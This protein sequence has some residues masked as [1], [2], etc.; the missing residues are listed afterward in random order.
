MTV[1][2][3]SV[4]DYSTGSQYTYGDTSGKW[5]SIQASGGSVNGNAGG[6]FDNT[7]SHVVLSGP[8]ASASAFSLVSSAAPVSKHFPPALRVRRMVPLDIEC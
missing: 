3:V 1:Q 2:S 6:S 4:V 5:T 8:S 7:P